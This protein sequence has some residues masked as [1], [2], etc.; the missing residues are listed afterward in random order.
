MTSGKFNTHYPLLGLDVV[1][2]EHGECTG[3][4]KPNKEE[5][6]QVELI[7]KQFL[8]VD[9]FNLL[10]D[11]CKKMNINTKQGKNFTKHS[12]RTLLTNPRYVGKWYRNKHNA[13]KRQ[14]KLMPYER[15]TE[16]ELDHGCVIGKDLWQRVQ[17]KVKELDES[18]AQ[19]TRHCYPLSGLLVFSDGSNFAGSSA[20]GNTRRSTYYYNNANKIRVRTEIFEAAVETVLRQ[21]IE[22]SPEFQASIANYSAQKA[23]ALSVVA[24]KIAEIDTRL[25]ELADERQRL[26]RRLNFLLEDDDLEMARS[27]RGEYKERVSAMKGEERELAD[28]KRQLQFVQK[29]IAAAQEPSKNGGLE[30][31]NKALGYIKSKDMASLKSIYR[32]LF[33]K[34]IVQP[35]DAAKVELQFVFNNMAASF[36]NGEVKFCASSALVDY[37]N[38]DTESVLIPHFLSKLSIYVASPPIPEGV[39]IQKYL[40]NRLS[41]QDIARELACSKTHV[42]RLLLKYNIPL[43]KTSDY[44]GSRWYAYGKQRVGGKTIDHKSEQR[45]IATIKQMYSEGISTNAIARFFNTMKIPTKQQGKS[46]HQNTVAKILKREGVYV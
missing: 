9:R 20:W 28:R 23:T 40:K 8:R 38:R 32:R 12:I 41:M 43:R 16:V 27:F 46:W 21:I 26:D 42:R 30:Q 4:Y 10:I 39:L 37:S 36:A 3:I 22:N 19:A 5:L 7:M 1:R 15:Y 34:I 29:Q 13:G 33:K 45:T 18:R 17:D 25:D 31:I 6:K 24:G 2:N 35:L 44:S 11:W 14:N